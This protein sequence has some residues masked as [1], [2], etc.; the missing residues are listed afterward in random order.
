MWKLLNQEEKTESVYNWNQ[1]EEDARSQ[2]SNLT[3]IT[4]KTEQLPT[5]VDTDFLLIDLREPEDYEQYHIRESLN[6]PG[7]HIKRDKYI[8]QL[9][10]YKNREGKIIVVYHFDEK[11]GMDYVTQLSEKGFDNLFLLSGGIE[12]FGQE[13]PEGLEGK[14]V[15]QF[16]KKEEVRKFKKQ[17]AE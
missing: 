14:A 4:I 9:Y 12:G 15:P 1:P 3:S 16:K 11:P 6:F 8:P 13:L 7:T 10:Q 5:G 17:R 2:T